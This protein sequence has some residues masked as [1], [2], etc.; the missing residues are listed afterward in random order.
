MMVGP[1]YAPYAYY[2][3]CLRKKAIAP[4]W[5]SHITLRV[6]RGTDRSKRLEKK[7]LAKQKNF[8]RLKHF[9]YLA[10]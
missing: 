6:L 5:K 2:C 3:A 4:L 1:L 9:T 8:L 7:K 10:S